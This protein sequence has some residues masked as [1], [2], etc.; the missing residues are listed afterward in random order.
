MILCP[1]KYKSKIIETPD[2]FNNIKGYIDSDREAKIS[3][4]KFLRINLKFMVELI[5]GGEIKIQAFQV[6][7]LKAFLNRN[8]TMCV[9]GR[10]LGKSWTSALFIVLQMIFQRESKIIIAS[11][12]YRTAKIIFSYIE[13]IVTHRNAKLLFD[14]FDVECKKGGN[15][16]QRWTI[17]GGEV[18]A[19][20]LSGDKI[21]GF[22]ANILVLDEFLNIPESVVENVLMP[23]LVSPQNL[24]E[25]NR[26]REMEDR[27]IN[28]GLM[29]ESERTKFPNTSKLLAMSSASY[30][31]EN[32]AKTFRKWDSIINGEI[33][34]EISTYC[35]MQLAW[36]CAPPQ[37]IDKAVIEMAQNGGLENPSFLREYCAQFTD[38]TDGYYSGVKL[39]AA[40]IPNGERP[41]ALIA[42]VKGK[43]YILSIDPNF[44]NSTTADDFAMAVLEID[45]EKQDATLVHCYAFA[46]ADISQHVNYIYYL[47]THFNIVLII[48][49]NA[50]SQI[51]ESCNASKIFIDN[52]I[53]L[54]TI[55]FNST[56]AGVD[57]T[58][59][60]Q[61]FKSNYNLDS[62]RIAFKQTFSTE[63]IRSMNDKLQDAINRKKIWF[64]SPASAWA[65]ASS[66]QLDTPV[67]MK[68][69]PYES[70][71]DFI[72][73][74]GLLIERTK[75]QCAMI[76]I[77]VT[78]KGSLDFDLPEHAKRDR[79]EKRAR[80]DSYTALLLGNWAAKVWFDLQRQQD[81]PVN[82]TFVPRMVG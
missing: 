69:V 51:I 18:I 54:G 59:E 14:I 5:T 58:K 3:L 46:G 33:T 22:R 16:D 57:Y 55:D 1:D 75:N 38:G 79:G 81:A 56:A 72:D 62:K 21:R 78:A 6:M 80:K 35:T 19:I 45:E 50:G 40:T 2:Y 42:G 67:D 65:S 41:H 47:L 70:K 66:E 71:L 7:M 11:S 8:F 36:N 39:M 24:S 29:Q 15:S 12:N 32:L 31:F 4:A 30:S 49:D 74:Q 53:E 63:S 20:P 52:R 28:Q 17:N 73:Q 37:F 10:G 48:C 68:L 44:S 23:F 9:A 82:V 26:V 13:K 34:D 61:M 27:L 77:S 25:Q 43:K 64:A 60:L 76:K